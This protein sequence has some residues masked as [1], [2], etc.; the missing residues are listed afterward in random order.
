MASDYYM[1]KQLSE[2]DVVL[3]AINSNLHIE[4]KRKDCGYTVLINA[5]KYYGQVVA[6][7]R[8]EDYDLEEPEE[9]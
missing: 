9:D 7:C 2:G 1:S 5:P 4:V 3:F 8:L 6:D